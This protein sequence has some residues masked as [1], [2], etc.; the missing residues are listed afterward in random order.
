[1]KSFFFICVVLC[2]LQAKILSAEQMQSIES[3]I[4]KSDL[5]IQGD[6]V[7]VAQNVIGTKSLEDYDIIYIKP[8]RI[9]KSECCNVTT[10][11][12]IP[13]VARA[14]VKNQPDTLDTAGPWGTQIRLPIESPTKGAVYLP[15]DKYNGLLFLKI[16]N[17]RPDDLFTGSAKWRDLEVKSSDFDSLCNKVEAIVQ[18]D[19]KKC[20]SW[21]WPT[22]ALLFV[23]GA[24]S[25][26]L[27]VMVVKRN[28]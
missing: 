8:R 9:I 23:L 12:V 27:I 26:A 25:G 22:V 7:R 16:I 21:S 11:S 20:T 14:L 3:L 28:R 2:F 18:A 6:V 4:R 19:K 1:M 5:V 10:D 24:G 15:A 17:T 13:V